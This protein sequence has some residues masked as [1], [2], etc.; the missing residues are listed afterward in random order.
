MA[1]GGGL[2]EDVGAGI[3]EGAL[4]FH[5]DAEVVFGVFGFPVCAGKVEGVE[6]SGVGAVSMLTLRKSERDFI[7]ALHRT[8]AM[9]K[10]SICGCCE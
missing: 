1:A 2:E 10:S 4:L 5:L 8:R 9:K 3:A 7:G 6:E